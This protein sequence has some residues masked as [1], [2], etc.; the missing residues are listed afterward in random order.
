M[1]ELNKGS[2]LAEM[3]KLLWVFAFAAII[4]AVLLQPRLQVTTFRIIAPINLGGSW[5]T[6][7]LLGVIAFA[8]ALMAATGIPL[9]DKDI[10]LAFVVTMAAVAAMFVGGEVGACAIVGMAQRDL[11]LI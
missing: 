8:N 10:A 5:T 2:K 4:W 9:G 1:S 7:I 11:G 6:D 3:P